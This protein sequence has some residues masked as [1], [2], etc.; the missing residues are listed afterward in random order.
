MAGIMS[1]D[2]TLTIHPSH[3]EAVA[4]RE[5]G[6]FVVEE[7]MGKRDEV[8]AW[9]DEQEQSLVVSRFFPVQ[10]YECRY[11]HHLVSPND[12]NVTITYHAVDG[13]SVTTVQS[14]KKIVKP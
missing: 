9:W 7:A 3:E 12:L 2:A 14:F 11:V 4:A 6:E 1:M 10:K 8:V 13:T 5:R